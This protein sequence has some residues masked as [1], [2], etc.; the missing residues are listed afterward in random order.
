MYCVVHLYVQNDH[1]VFPRQRERERE[2]E[3]ETE[4]ETET[5]RNVM[6]GKQL[7]S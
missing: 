5:E 3:M 2:R 4:T 7:N 1:V 6:K